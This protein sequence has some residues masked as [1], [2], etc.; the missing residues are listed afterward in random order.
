MYSD[1]KLFTGHFSCTIRSRPIDEGHRGELSES[2][3]SGSLKLSN[4][5]DHTPKK[6]LST[7]TENE[8]GEELFVQEYEEYRNVLSQ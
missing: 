8:D 1:T 3:T 6:P 7:S 2:F 4:S 5:D